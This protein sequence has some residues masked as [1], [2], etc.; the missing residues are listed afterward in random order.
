MGLRANKIT[1]GKEIKELRGWVDTKV[2]MV[3]L[4]EE[5]MV[6]VAAPYGV[7]MSPHLRTL[8]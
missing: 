5:A 4:V 8:L 6:V 2:A 3:V 7:Q 1:G